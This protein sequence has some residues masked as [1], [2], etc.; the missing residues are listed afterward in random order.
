MK[1]NWRRFECIISGFQIAFGIII[2]L[3]IIQTILDYYS[4]FYINP[5]FNKGDILLLSFRKNYMLFIVAFLSIISG[6]M[7]LKSSLNGWILSIITWI[8]YAVLIIISFL[9]INQD[10]SSILDYESKIVIGFMVLLFI[11]ILL[12]FTSKE[13]KMKY[14]PNKSNFIF[15]VG[16]VLGLTIVKLLYS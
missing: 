1:A 5:L 14:K 2:F 16:V 9:K 4:V 6:I 13:F 11:T 3:I 8:M 7:L 15:I 10:K 12:L